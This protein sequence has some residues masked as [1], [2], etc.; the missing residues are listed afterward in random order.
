MLSSRT[1]FFTSSGLRFECRTHSLWEGFGPGLAGPSWSAQLDSAHISHAGWM[2]LVSEYTRRTLTRA[3]DRLP[4]AA[5]TMRRVA[6]ARGWSHRWGMWTGAGTPV[7][8]LAWQAERYTGVRYKHLCAVRPGF[9]APSWAWASVEGPVTYRYVTGMD[10]ARDP[11]TEDAEVREWDLPSGVIRVAGRVITRTI[12]CHVT[13]FPGDPAVPGVI[14]AEP[15]GLS[16]R[17]TMA[18]LAPQSKDEEVEVEGMEG[19]PVTPDSALQPW[20]GVVV[21]GVAESTVV[22]VPHGD[23]LPDRSWAGECRCLMLVRQKLRCVVLLLGRSR[24]VPGA[25]ER[26][27]LVGGP[28]PA[29]WDGAPR[30][31]LDIA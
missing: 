26:I 4:A 2:D 5:A 25:W 9:Y 30:V 23:P 21:D 31:E 11:K 16:H 1:V 29:C 15:V 20:T 24:R 12:R 13:E 6:K 22:R 3:S 8:T 7:D 28:D 10:T 14:E 17:Y 18:G 19:M 27:A